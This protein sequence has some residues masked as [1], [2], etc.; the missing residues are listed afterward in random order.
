MARHAPSVGSLRFGVSLDRRMPVSVQVFDQIR[1]EIVEATLPPGT[2]LSEVALSQ[3]FGVSRTPIRESL[4]RLADEGL[5]QIIPQVGTYVTKISLIKVYEAQFIR[6]ALECAGIR[7]AATSP[8]LQAE[9]LV[10]HI[11]DQRRAI[12][13]G[14]LKDFYAADEALHA[15]FAD[16][17]GHPRVWEIALAEKVHLDRVRMLDVSQRTDLGEIVEQHAAIVNAVIARDAVAA[18]M[19]MRTHLR[20]ALARLKPLIENNRSYFENFDVSGVAA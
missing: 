5:V 19:A 20:D 9:T 4:L 6:E 18:E 7:S 3:K 10:R 8:K 1:R 11:K 2:P 16:A 14:S 12:K 15:T 17:S 13:S